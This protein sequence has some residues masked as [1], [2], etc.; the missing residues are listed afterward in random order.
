MISAMGLAKSNGEAR[1]LIQAGAV[2]LEGEKVDDPFASMPVKDL[3]GKVLR[4]GKHQFRK[5]T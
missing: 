4:V 1:R 3:R 5:L 2:S